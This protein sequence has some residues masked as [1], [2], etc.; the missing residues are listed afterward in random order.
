MKKVIM[1]ILLLTLSTSLIYA[2]CPEVVSDCS[3]S[4]PSQLQ[5]VFTTDPMHV[6]DNANVDQ[7]SQISSV[8]LAK[9]AEDISSEDL[10]MLLESSEGL[11]EE[12]TDIDLAKAL[13]KNPAYSSKLESEDLKRA[14]DAN[15]DL[16]MESAVLDSVDTQLDKDATFLNNNPDAVTTWFGQKGGYIVASENTKIG[17]FDKESGE[18][19]IGKGLSEEEGGIDITGSFNI[20]DGIVDGID[21][22]GKLWLKDGAEI[23]NANV[24]LDGTFSRITQ[25]GDLRVGL[26]LPDNQYDDYQLTAGSKVVMVSKYGIAEIDE[27]QGDITVHDNGNSLSI[28]TPIDFE[29]DIGDIVKGTITFGPDHEVIDFR[30]EQSLTISDTQIFG[31]DSK[32]SIKGT[33]NSNLIGSSASDTFTELGYGTG[34]DN[35]QARKEA[36]ESLGLGEFGGTSAQNT[37]LLNKLKSGE[38]KVTTKTVEGDFIYTD[39]GSVLLKSTKDYDSTFVDLSKNFK[40]NS[41]GRPLAI[42]PYGSTDI[43]NLGEFNGLVQYGDDFMAFGQF[44]TSQG[45]FS[46]KSKESIEDSSEFLIEHS[47]F[48]E[49]YSKTKKLDPSKFEIGSLVLHSDNFDQ[50]YGKCD[51]EASTY[52]YEGLVD[53]STLIRAFNEVEQ[54]YIDAD[55]KGDIATF[56]KKFDG[57]SVNDLSL[58]KEILEFP[59]LISKEDDVVISNLDEINKIFG[60]TGDH[61]IDSFDDFVIQLGD[62][63]GIVSS[64]NLEVDGKNM[65]S[66]AFV[67]GEDKALLMDPRIVKESYG[68]KISNEDLIIEALVMRNTENGQLNFN[69]LKEDLERFS[70]ISDNPTINFKLASLEL[71]SGNFVGA[72]K[73]YESVL[74]KGTPEQNKVAQNFLE[75]NKAAKLAI[76]EGALEQLGVYDEATRDKH[77]WMKYYE[78]TMSGELEYTGKNAREGW[79]TL[80][81]AGYSVLN[82]WQWYKTSVGR[83]NERLD[84]ET[85]VTGVVLDIAKD[86]IKK[87]EASTMTDVYNI[88]ENGEGSLADQFPEFA[89]RLS[90]ERTNEDD[91]DSQRDMTRNELST[92][93]YQNPTLNTQL[94]VEEL[95]QSNLG[96]SGE[97]QNDLFLAQARNFREQGYYNDAAQMY[98]LVMENDPVAKAEYDDMVGTDFFDWSD[99]SL[100][101]FGDTSA[102]FIGEMVG[103][104]IFVS[105]VAKLG[106]KG[107]QYSGLASKATSAVSK[108]GLQKLGSYSSN[109]LSKLDDM[110]LLS[111]SEGLITTD[112][113]VS[114]SGARFGFEAGVGIGGDFIHPSLGVIGDVLTGGGGA[115]KAVRESVDDLVVD[116]VEAVFRHSD[117][118]ISPVLRASD[119]SG[120]RQLVAQADG[121]AIIEMDEGILIRNAESSTLVVSPTRSLD[122][123]NF[124]LSSQITEALEEAEKISLSQG[125]I[126][127]ADDLVD[128]NPSLSIAIHSVPDQDLILPGSRVL[129]DTPSPSEI[130]LE[131]SDSVSDVVVNIEPGITDSFSLSV[132]E[133]LVD[134]QDLGRVVRNSENPEYGRVQDKITTGQDVRG[135]FVDLQWTHNAPITSINAIFDSGVIKSF[136][137][138]PISRGAQFRYGLSS[139]YGEIKF[140][141][142]SNFEDG[143]RGLDIRETN[144]HVIVNEPFMLDMFAKA[145]SYY[146]KKMSMDE[147]KNAI[148]KDYT[149]RSQIG[150]ESID[151]FSKSFYNPQMHIADDVNLDA[152]DKV[153]VPEHLYDEVFDS[154]TRNGFDTSKLVKVEGT[155]SIGEYYAYNRHLGIGSTQSAIDIGARRLDLGRGSTNSIDVHPASFAKEEEAYMKVLLDNQVPSSKDIK[156]STLS[157]SAHDSTWSTIAENTPN[158]ESISPFYTGRSNEYYWYSLRSNF[159]PSPSNSPDQWKVFINPKDENYLEVLER[160]VK[161][162]SN[163]DDIELK[164]I[165]GPSSKLSDPNEPKIVLY[166]KDDDQLRSI[167]QKIDSEFAGE[168]SLLGADAGVRN[169]VFQE[170]PSFTKKFSD[171]I[172]YTKGG[173]S[174]GISPVSGKSKSDVISD[175]S[176]EKGR[177][178]TREEISDA[179]TEAGFDGEN[180]YKYSTDSDPLEG[181][182]TN[183]EFNSQSMDLDLEGLDGNKVPFLGAI[184][185]FHY[186]SQGNLLTA[187]AAGGTCSSNPINLNGINPKKEIDSIRSLSNYLNDPD[188]SY[189]KSAIETLEN[190]LKSLENRISRLDDSIKNSDPNLNELNIEIL[191]LRENL[192]KFHFGEGDYDS[193]LVHLDKLEE[194]VIIRKSSE[195]LGKVYS[196]KATVLSKKAQKELNLGNYD[197]AFN[198]F[199]ASN[200][201]AINPNSKSTLRA[202]LETQA[203]IKADK[204]I[205]FEQQNDFVN[206]FKSQN[207][208]LQLLKEAG[209]TIDLLENQDLKRLYGKLESSSFKQSEKFDRLDYESKKAYNFLFNKDKSPDLQDNTLFVSKRNEIET[210]ISELK[211]SIYNS[212]PLKQYELEIYEDILQALKE[213]KD[214]NLDLIHAR[215]NDLA[216]YS[217]SNSKDGVMKN[218]LGEDVSVG[219][220]VLDEFNKYT[221]MIITDSSEWKEVVTFDDNLVRNVNFE[222]FKLGLKEKSFTSSQSGESSFLGV[223]DGTYFGVSRTETKIYG[224]I[225]MEFDMTARDAV[226][227][228]NAKM[229]YVPSVTVTDSRQALGSPTDLSGLKKGDTNIDKLFV[230]A[231]KIREFR[232]NNGGSGT[233]QKGV[234]HLSVEVIVPKDV[235]IG[236]SHLRQVKV[237][238]E[239]QKEEIEIL[240][241]QVWE[242]GGY[243]GSIPEVILQNDF[244]GINFNRDPYSTELDGILKRYEDN[245]NLVDRDL[246]KLLSMVDEDQFLMEN[247]PDNLKEYIFSGKQDFVASIDNLVN[248]VVAP[249]HASFLSLEQIGVT[250]LKNPMGENVIQYKNRQIILDD[251]DS[252]PTRR[253]YGQYGFL[254]ESNEGVETILYK[255]GENFRIGLIDVDSAPRFEPSISN[256]ENMERGI[257][258]IIIKSE[259]YYEVQEEELALSR[260]RSQD[261][262]AFDAAMRNLYHTQTSAQFAQ[263]M[264]SLSSE[265]LDDLVEGTGMARNDLES[266]VRELSEKIKSEYLGGMPSV[267]VTKLS[268]LEKIIESGKIQ[269]PNPPSRRDA[270]K[271][272]D[273]DVFTFFADPG[274]GAYGD[275]VI[276]KPGQTF[277]S[278]TIYLPGDLTNGIQKDFNK[279]PQSISFGTKIEQAVQS[280]D[281]IQLQAEYM[282]MDILLRARSI[283]KNLDSLSESLSEQDILRYYV[284]NMPGS[285]QKRINDLG[286]IGRIEGH[287]PEID[288]QEGAV[289]MVGSSQLDAVRLSLEKE[290]L[291]G[292]IKVIGVEGNWGDFDT[293][294]SGQSGYE[295]LRM[296]AYAY[297]SGFHTGELID[298]GDN[299]FR[300][301]PDPLPDLTLKVPKLKPLLDGNQIKEI[302]GLSDGPE[303]G[304]IIKELNNLQA[305]G[306]ITTADEAIELLKSQN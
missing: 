76:L 82:P 294:Y 262:G 3:L 170:G 267:H 236:L 52:T 197:S 231:N 241:K 293:G 29:T 192:V 291:L 256:V 107:L 48:L 51:V 152:V 2:E 91:S 292:K 121:D 60:A 115:K 20:N 6:I 249:D 15:I 246:S 1:L 243:T 303:L 189:R 211:N 240:L 277:N 195:N 290:G 156:A 95:V 233:P 23:A 28:L 287:S 166:I 151:E 226:N 251:L 16:M 238:S 268:T 237:N 228:L 286:A 103:G 248:G 250:I 187:C 296:A 157:Q 299:I 25:I 30:S 258:D 184:D 255:S 4:D 55:E 298:E 172:Y 110:K 37:E 84:Y 136:K 171:L 40:A 281:A 12:L 224:E 11:A 105:G 32:I 27:S 282:A 178:L 213:G 53:S 284:E 215:E 77:P 155:G 109:V 278:E 210:K 188:P 159:H 9:Y 147:L 216:A 247:L 24:K 10:G 130:F 185:E 302:T 264:Q 7:L 124:V 257:E 117:G 227:D 98:A 21:D 111:T 275:I 56:A 100:D 154:A 161:S 191:K 279:A 61:F 31:I 65:R 225:E 280:S 193:A 144:N 13:S 230:E 49:D 295:K 223:E 71:I 63:G 242:E 190:N 182:S 198:L 269:N 66:I 36:Y 38:L 148:A 93:F 254:L 22:S 252:L 205:R 194:S 114:I 70:E 304:K 214:V 106:I 207:E 203:S 135:E 276:L 69:V 180:F 97:I 271:G 74:G 218:S 169:G 212:D 89:D 35:Y 199:E 33:L 5:M 88:I 221:K 101:N 289:I 67:K 164:A 87:G 142:K 208:R 217:W 128:T 177:T 120:Y 181:L 146:G 127:A 165:G 8:D 175:L 204:A 168:S 42:T 72:V 129:D 245:G 81:E 150:E 46:S 118:S 274:A 158:F 90:V 174:E 43:N 54:I 305:E 113:V 119:D 206:A 59:M 139:D 85:Q 239:A 229:N 301:T 265:I 209:H 306:K 68:D 300:L 160:V 126:T 235:D 288:I 112:G 260:L 83:D 50:V 196:S 134:T 123:E 47:K 80:I 285:T 244:Q 297:E 41:I 116:S 73:L 39:K 92:M 104:G 173:M 14:V 183:T 26:E 94:K 162:V 17:S 270:F 122:E 79:Q 57:Y 19:S 131:T 179:L 45:E 266:I 259:R 263:N 145:E 58:N 222:D 75:Q 273:G 64:V 133:E 96:F 201:Y 261:P 18:I 153:L 140:V 232:M 283:G 78:K 234:G 125:L 149:F 253:I 272:A 220:W 108:L 62:T 200:F 143:R 86:L 99:S 167:V 132:T 163:E 137:E 44:S 102:N 34:Q 219:K 176:I 138:D 141:M 186:D 202:N